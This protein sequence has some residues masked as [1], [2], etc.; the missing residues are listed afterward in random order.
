[1]WNKRKGNMKPKRIGTVVVDYS[2]IHSPSKTHQDFLLNLKTEKHPVY[3]YRG[4]YIVREYGVSN[5]PSSSHYSIYHNFK[6]GEPSGFDFHLND[7]RGFKRLEDAAFTIDSWLKE[8][9]KE[10]RSSYEK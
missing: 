3:E 8:T 7:E 2:K 9:G 10:N 4:Y 6:D 5:E 1:M